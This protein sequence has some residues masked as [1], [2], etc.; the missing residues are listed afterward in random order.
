M[1][2]IRIDT[3]YVKEVGWRLLVESDRIVEVGRELGSA[4]GSLDTGAWDGASRARAEPLLGRVQPKRASLVQ[5][6]GRLAR[7]LRQVVEAFEREDRT[8]AHHLAALPWVDWDSGSGPVASTITSNPDFSGIER[9]KDAEYRFVMGE[10]FLQGENDETAIHPNDVE[11][12][13]VG[14]CYFISSLAALAT[15]AAGRA[16]LA[17]NIRVNDD[18]TYTVTLYERDDS[19]EFV[20]VEVDVTSEFPLYKNG[21]PAFAHPGDRIGIQQ[22]LWPM[23]YEKAYAKHM[24]GYNE[25]AGGWGAAAMETLTG[26]PSEAFVTVVDLPVDLGLG[27]IAGGMEHNRAVPDTVRFGIEFDE[28]EAHFNA[29]EAITVGSLPLSLEVRRRLDIEALGIHQDLHLNP[30]AAI[31]PVYESDNVVGCHEYYLVGMDPQTRQVQLRNPWGYDRGLIK[32]QWDEFQKAF[33]FISVN[34]MAE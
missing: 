32:V 8:A 16:L 12:G 26:Q 13:D 18:D 1:T 9:A 14:D 3:E 25:I 10:P 33:P 19:G 28:L 20:P 17:S 30:L 15:T 4:I 29:G 11:Q 7:L 24:G 31:L 23:I 21:D 5:G 22:E 2:Q 34:P 6:L 27:E